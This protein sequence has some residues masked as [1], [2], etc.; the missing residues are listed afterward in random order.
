MT[1]NIKDD[2]IPKL[3]DD[4]LI[5]KEDFGFLV[6]NPKTD[7]VFQTNSVGAEIIHLC[8]GKVNIADISMIITE[9]FEVEKETAIN[10]V[11]AFL[12]ELIRLDLIEY[13]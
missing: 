9:I 5:R 2:Q 13:V 3:S 1:E 12:F 11:K 10:D 7:T 6:F 4:L 8:D